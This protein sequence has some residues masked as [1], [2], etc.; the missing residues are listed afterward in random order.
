[1]TT[2]MEMVCQL[3][4]VPVEV[5]D[6]ATEIMTEVRLWGFQ[7]LLQIQ[8][9]AI[10]VASCDVHLKMENSL[11]FLW[12]DVLVVDSSF[13]NRSNELF[14]FGSCVEINLFL[15]CHFWLQRVGWV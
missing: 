10:L 3:A 14:F 15:R 8:W 11:I 4:S 5:L 7:E 2:G 6:N 9:T 12:I 13:E 1:M